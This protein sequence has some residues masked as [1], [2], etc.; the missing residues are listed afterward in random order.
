MPRRP[1]YRMSRGRWQVE[2]ER[3]RIAS[4]EPPTD[5]AATCR[6]GDVI[7][8]LLRQAGLEER[9]WEQALL[10]EWNEMAG[11][12]VARRARPGRLQRKVLVI[13]V[14]NSA[15][16]NELSR[17]GQAPL[18]ANLQKRFGADRIQSLRFQLD[19]D[20]PGR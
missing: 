7:P 14:S 10:S 19:P 16:L 11:E 1:Q 12:Q 18:L 3:C 5:P 6:A 9:L 4:H 2:Q 17:Y 15:W 13:F 20:V 8:G